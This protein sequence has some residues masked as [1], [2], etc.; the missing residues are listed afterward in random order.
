[1]RSL[2]EA[3]S[4]LDEAQWHQSATPHGAVKWLPLWLF[5]DTGLWIGLDQQARWVVGRPGSMVIQDAPPLLQGWLPMLDHDELA[6]REELT[7]SADKYGLPAEPILES[8]PIDDVIALALKSHSAHWTE[9]A[10]TW[11]E[12]RNVRDDIREMLPALA[13]SKA[14]GQRARQIAQRLMKQG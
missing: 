12:A 4:R 10:L 8:L 9:R 13:S 1:M 5:S 11:L 3:L 7:F 14:A 2:Q 6:A